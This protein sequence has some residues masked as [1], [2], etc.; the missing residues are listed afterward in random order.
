MNTTVRRRPP[1]QP[2]R[3]AAVAF[4]ATAAIAGA[5]A[6][7]VAVVVDHAQIDMSFS[8]STEAGP[9]P[10]AHAGGR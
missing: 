2:L 4:A 8:G 3:R 1:A 9:A 6:T 10:T 5:S 7:T